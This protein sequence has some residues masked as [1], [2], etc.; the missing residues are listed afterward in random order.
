[1]RTARQAQSGPRV[2]RA[3]RSRPGSANGGRERRRST[4]WIS[5][6]WKSATKAGRWASRTRIGSAD[7]STP[8]AASTHHRHPQGRT[9]VDFF[10]LIAR[11]HR[12]QAADQ[13]NYRWMLPATKDE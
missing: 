12:A 9:G 11:Q 8:K 5:R 1:M 7:T 2:R 10:A 3:R 4:H 6:A 13:I